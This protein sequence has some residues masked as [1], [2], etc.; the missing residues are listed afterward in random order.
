MV[1]SIGRRRSRAIAAVLIAYGLAG[2]VILGILTSAV[3]P[4]TN[5]LDTIA[6]SSADVG[7]VLAS[8][9]DAF[10]G[11]GSSLTEAQRS[12][13]RAAAAARSSSQAARGLAN[14][15]SIS[16]FGAQ[17]LASLASGFRQQA[18][19]LSALA[20]ELDVLARSLSQNGADVRELREEV[21][22]L[23]T[24]ATWLGSSAQGPA[25]LVP[26]LLLV[27]LWLAVPP[28][29]ALIVGVL[30]LRASTGHHAARR[31]S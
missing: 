21:A 12:A 15:M 8:T 5:T 10:D 2:V 6:R 20:D 18:D 22:T 13:E 19:D 27:I 17:P 25:W 16:I 28:I 11:F 3:I 4:M 23:H 7:Q 24:R 14:G 9:R 1:R 30:L 29:G 26:A 31:A